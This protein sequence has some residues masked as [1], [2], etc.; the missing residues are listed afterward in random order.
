M[1]QIGIDSIKKHLEN[2]PHSPG[3][4]QMINAEGEVIYVGKAKNLNKRVTSYTRP[5][6]AY[7]TYLMTSLVREVRI[8]T[9]NSESEAFLLE[10][11]LVK[12]LQ[13][14][15]N[16]LLKDD[17]SFP[18]LKLRT[19]HDF[20]QIMKYRGKISED[21]KLFGPYPSVTSLDGVIHDLQKIF[22]IRPCSDNYFKNR[23]RPCIQYEIKRCSAPCVGKISKEEYAEQIAQIEKFLKGK[24]QELQL[25][26]AKDMQKLSE[27][28]EYEKA[29]ALRDKIKALSYVQSKA[30]T[31]D[32]NIENADVIALHIDNA[33]CA[34]QVMMFRSAGSSGGK[35]YFPA[36][37]KDSSESEILEA[38]LGFFYQSIEPPAE[39]ILS[40][41]IENK[42]EI[43]NA[44]SSMQDVI[45]ASLAVI[46]AQAGI[47]SNKLDPRLRG[48]DI[49]C[50]ITTPKPNSQKY[51]LIQHALD[52]AKLALATKQKDLAKKSEILDKI[53]N[54]F[55]LTD[56]IQRIELYDNSHISGKFAVGAM[57]VANQEGLDKKSYRTYN[58]KQDQPEF[59]G[60]DYAM[61]REVLTRRLSKLD[62]KNKPSLIILDG[63]IGQLNAVYDVMQKLNIK[64]PLI[65]MS[66]GEDRNAGREVFHQIGKDPFTLERSDEVMK[67]LQLMRNEVHNLAIRS[68]RK[69]RSK[70]ISASELDQIEGIGAKRKNILLN[71]FGSLDKIKQATMEELAVVDN[72]GKKFA[73]RIYNGLH[74]KTG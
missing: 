64:I 16:I 70:A 5:D 37:T 34:I 8:I 74:E 30:L 42:E 31:T 32:F 62:D 41:E 10:A 21:G 12:K 46:P 1:R 51:K 7:R 39:I 13:P 22:K 54:L 66:K 20:P 15:Y 40:H 73:E 65:A 47:Y 19:D 68:H 56:K 3:I 50:V 48:D 61:M 71:Y 38:F 57:V 44:I 72:I 9:T 67:Y 4:Y 26:L 6:V 49:K 17:K 33:E 43:A 52:N 55:G 58:I 53:Q 63:G 18:Y 69:L 2:I 45:H 23:K 11:S 27:N 14:K 60:D 36:N 59:G 29:A 24:N 28:F 25:D 35:C